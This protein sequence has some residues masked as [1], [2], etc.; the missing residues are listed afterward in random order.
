MMQ[1]VL[2]GQVLPHQLACAAGKIFPTLSAE[3][4]HC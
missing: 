1:W 4:I 2:A 3:G